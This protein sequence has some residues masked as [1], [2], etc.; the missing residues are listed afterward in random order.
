[1]WVYKIAAPR[2]MEPCSRWHQC[3]QNEALSGALQW[4]TW[5][6]RSGAHPTSFSMGTE[7]K[8]AGVWSWSLTST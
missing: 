5:Y 2:V 1:M 3:R 8:A 4:Y 6:W 7:V